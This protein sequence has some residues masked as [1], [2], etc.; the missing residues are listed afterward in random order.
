MRIFGR[1]VLQGVGHYLHLQDYLS[2][3]VHRSR[4]IAFLGKSLRKAAVRGGPGTASR[5][6]GGILTYAVGLG[7]IELNCVDGV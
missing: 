7:I 5:T 3:A 2:V 6:I 1:A 4:I